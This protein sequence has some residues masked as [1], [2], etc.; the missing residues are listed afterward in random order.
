M[1]G[2]RRRLLKGVSFLF[3]PKKSGKKDFESGEEFVE[4]FQPGKRLFLR[5]LKVVS[6]VKKYIYGFVDLKEKLSLSAHPEREEIYALNYRDIAIIVGNTDVID[7]PSL[8]KELLLQKLAAHQGV[9]EEIMKKEP[10]LPVKFGTVMENNEEVKELLEKVYPEARKALERMGDKVELD[11]VVSWNDRMVFE[12]IL[13]ED[14]EVLR[15]KRKLREETVPTIDTK[16]ELGKRVYQLLREKGQKY[17]QEIMGVLQ[18]E[19]EDSR[20]NRVLPDKMV[21]NAAFLIRRHQEKN[22]ESKVLDLNERYGERFHFRCVGPLPP[23]SFFTLEV[24]KVSGRELDWS[25]QVL[26]VNKEESPAEVKSLYHQL[27]LKYHPD[28]CGPEG[29]EKFRQIKRAYQILNDYYTHGRFWCQFLQVE[30][31]LQEGERV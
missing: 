10:I 14:E 18:E 24:K 30:S 21:L 3:N 1:A 23:Y 12:D 7:F 31:G 11:I 6:T 19:T 25:R 2:V 28:S 27:I 13:R 22:L 5:R 16:I 8:N 26:G 29:E 20:I 15:M 17:A 4:N 9:I